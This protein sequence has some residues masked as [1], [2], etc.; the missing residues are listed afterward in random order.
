MD[1]YNNTVQ[2]NICIDIRTYIRTYICEEIKIVALRMYVPTYVCTYVRTYVHMS[3]IGVFA[4]WLCPEL[5]HFKLMQN[6][7]RRQ[8]LYHYSF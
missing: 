7:G 3:K 1:L 6:I 2:C 5:A 4:F 8:I